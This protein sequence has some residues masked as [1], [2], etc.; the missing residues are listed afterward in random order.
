ML[1]TRPG[2]VELVNIAVAKEKQGKG[3]GKQLVHHA[4][5]NAKTQGYKTMEVGTGNSSISQ[6]I[7]YQ[8]CG[9]RITGIDRDFFIRHYSEKIFE[10]GIRSEI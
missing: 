1:P 3:L 5:Q 10:N 6:L 4:K 8:K 7:L 9:F 2:T